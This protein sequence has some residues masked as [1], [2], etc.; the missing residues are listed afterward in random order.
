MVKEKVLFN[1]IRVKKL[2]NCE[3]KYLY[4]TVIYY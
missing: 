3:E 2:Q 1:S 4:S